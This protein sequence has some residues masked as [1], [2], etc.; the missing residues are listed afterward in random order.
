MFTVINVYKKVRTKWLGS[1]FII[2]LPLSGLLKS[3]YMSFFGD[4]LEERGRVLLIR[5]RG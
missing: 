4:I 5:D 3:G 2:W 1:L